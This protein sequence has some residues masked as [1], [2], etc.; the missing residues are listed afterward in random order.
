MYTRTENLPQGKRG[1]VVV[2]PAVLEVFVDPRT[3][4]GRSMPHIPV[5]GRSSALGAVVGLC[6]LARER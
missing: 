3:L 6:S 2:A 4:S 5:P 1:E